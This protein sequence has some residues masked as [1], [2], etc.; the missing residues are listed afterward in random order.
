MLLKG[1]EL[2]APETEASIFPQVRYNMP[3]PHLRD[4]PLGQEASMAHSGLGLPA[5]LPTRMENS[6]QARVGMC[7]VDTRPLGSIL[8]P[9]KPFHTAAKE[10][11]QMGTIFGHY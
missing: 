9:I 4:P 3:H 2:T 8:R 7:V 6:V 10:Q 1:D 11:Y 5:S